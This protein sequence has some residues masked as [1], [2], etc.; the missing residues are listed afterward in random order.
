M[1]NPLQMIRLQRQICGCSA[2]L[3]PF[4]ANHA[5]DWDGF[6]SHLQRTVDSGLIPAVN[7]DTGYTNLIDAATRAEVLRRTMAISGDRPYI[8]GV[9]VADRPGD[10]FQADAYRAGIEQIV[11]HRGTPIIFQS[12]GLVNQT[13]DAI[14]RCYES[15]ASH[16]E[17]LLFFE[18]APVFAPF[19]TI[20]SLE[21]YSR[22]MQIPA[23]TGAKHSSLRRDLEW[24]RIEIRDRI[25]PE[26]KV[27][28]GNDLAIDMVI[29]GSDYLLGLSTFAPE[30]FAVRDRYWASGDARFYQLNDLLQYLGAFTF[31]EPTPAYKHSAAMFLKLRGMLATDM[32]HS[33]SPTRPASDRAVLQLIADDLD[34]LLSEA[35]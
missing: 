27:F 35:R 31:R 1:L 30:A 24:Q 17:A 12:F 18:L 4:Q 19:G 29:Y 13:D 14:V 2:I 9:F 8:A 10:R 20:Y 7:M 33:Q 22:L 5:V 3:L 6:E 16:C 26:F 15:M 21:T 23:I 32:T 25:R 28:T 11:Q 34:R